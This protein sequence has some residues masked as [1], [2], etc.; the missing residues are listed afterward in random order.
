M[1]LLNTHK[2]TPVQQRIDVF[3]RSGFDLTEALSPH[4]A[5]MNS[6]LESKG[7]VVDAKLEDL[8]LH[9]VRE[10]A[11]AAVVSHLLRALG[12]R[13]VEDTVLAG[14]G[15]WLRVAS[16]IIDRGGAAGTILATCLPVITEC[17]PRMIENL[18]LQLLAPNTQVR[19][20]Q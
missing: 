19:R 15:L 20:Y 8:M 12:E 3:D 10:D 18:P 1:G 6:I 7:A 4:L 16:D 5:A 2:H 9:V 17:N 14:R 13:F 11:N